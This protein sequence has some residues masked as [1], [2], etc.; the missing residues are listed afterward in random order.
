M[1]TVAESVWY[2]KQ[3][4]RIVFSGGK[5]GDELNR[6][7]DAEFSI[8]KSSYESLHP[9]AATMSFEEHVRLADEAYD[10]RHPGRAQ[11][12]SRAR[13]GRFYHDNVSGSY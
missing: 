3:P 4:K 11:A 2:N 8:I 10:R 6:K 7:S 12:P 13:P 5:M 9:D 1:A